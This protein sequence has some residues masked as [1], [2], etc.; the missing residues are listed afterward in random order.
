[1][2]GDS[3][4]TVAKLSGVRFVDNG[5]GTITD[6]QTGLQ[7]E[8][9]TGSVGSFAF[10]DFNPDSGGTC[11]D[12]GDVNNLYDWN[13]ATGEWLSRLNGTTVDPDAQSGLGGHTDWRIPTLAEL[14]T[15]LDLSVPGCGVSPFPPCIDPI[16]DPLYATFYYS[17]STDS[18]NTTLGGVLSFSGGTVSFATKTT[19]SQPVRAVR[20]P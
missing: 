6:N 20:S 13:E 9:K 1:M 16:F 2:I 10:C 12:L 11:A 15:I 3:D 7:W 8:K 18:D 5:D 19:F 4:T 17:S 14:S